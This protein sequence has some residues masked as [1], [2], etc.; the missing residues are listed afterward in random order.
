MDLY[1]LSGSFPTA[2]MVEIINS[3]A[4]LEPQSSLDVIL[5]SGVEVHFA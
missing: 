1:S 2:R 5:R 3:R 4:S